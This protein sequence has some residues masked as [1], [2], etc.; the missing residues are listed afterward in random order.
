MA[1]SEEQLAAAIMAKITGNNLKKIDES[2]LT[3]VTPGMNANR[4][5]P[6]S[7]ISRNTPTGPSPIE[8]Q[9]M[10]QANREAERL[11]PLPQADLAPIPQMPPTAPPPNTT[12]TTYSIPAPVPV[13]Q[14]APVTLS[15]SIL[16][17]EDIVSIR[18]QLEKT[19]ATLTKMSGMLGKVFASFTE[20]NKINN[21]D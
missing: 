11:Y 20:K 7:F 21:S 4:L 13:S 18:S 1:V 19:N 6:M 17:R 8:I 3:P 15:E 14:P 2:S 16:T 10:Q 9:M 12:N 5:D